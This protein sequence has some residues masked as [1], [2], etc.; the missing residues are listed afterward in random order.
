MR[1]SVPVFNALVGTYPVFMLA[2]MGSAVSDEAKAVQHEAGR[3]ARLQS[4][5]SETL[6]GSK[7]VALTALHELYL[8]CGEPN[9]DGDGA[10]AL[11]ADAV[12][13]VIAFIRAL[14]H[15][16]SMPDLS[17]D[18]DGSIQLDWIPSKQRMF[19]INVGSRGQL[20]YAWRDGLSKG[21]AVAPF[22]GSNVPAIVLTAIQTIT[23]DGTPP[24]RPPSGN[25]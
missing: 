11:S 4:D 13:I 19:S 2:L 17:A 1:S 12:A 6:F 5:E 21:Y 3:V 16:A 24:F 7:R 18:P 15:W 10:K 9:W 23:T 22:D 14:P 25:C 8:N 20:A